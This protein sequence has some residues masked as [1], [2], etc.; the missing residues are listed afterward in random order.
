MT[1][2]TADDAVSWC[3]AAEALLLAWGGWVRNGPV[4]AGYPMRS[5]LHPDWSPG[6]G[7]G[8]VVAN[9]ARGTDAKLRA[10]HAQLLQ[11]TTSDKLRATAV[12]VYVRRW[13][14]ARCAD[15]LGCSVAAHRARLVALRRVAL[16]VRVA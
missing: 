7:A 10:L 14:E 1:R 6:R 8:A 3:A 12:A 9:A 2:P 15:E 11:P 16:R 13:P 4:V 5:V